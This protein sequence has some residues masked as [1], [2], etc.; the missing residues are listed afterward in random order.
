MIDSP[1]NCMLSLEGDNGVQQ[2]TGKNCRVESFTVDRSLNAE[3]VYGYGNKIMSLKTSLEPI[4]ITLELV[5]LDTDFL[6]EM[7]DKNHKPERKI[8]KLKVEDCS[9]EELMFAVRQKLNE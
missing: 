2:M 1:I 9:I 4:R 7:F 3:N 8:S 6:F 5:C